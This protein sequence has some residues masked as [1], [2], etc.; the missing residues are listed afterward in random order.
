MLAVMLRKML[1]RIRLGSVS[2]G[3]SVGSPKCFGKLRASSMI[4]S[5]MLPSAAWIHIDLREDELVGRDLVRRYVVGDLAVHLHELEA[6]D[7]HAHM[8]VSVAGAA[9]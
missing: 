9:K 8:L 1:S 3:R 2:P 6:E 4:W 5:S 7:V